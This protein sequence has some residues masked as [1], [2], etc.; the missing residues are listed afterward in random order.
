MSIILVTYAD[1][2]FAE[3]QKVLVEECKKLNIFDKYFSYDFDSLP[4]FLKTSPILSYSKGGGYWLWK[5]YIAIKAWDNAEIG[6]V[7]VVMDS[8]MVINSEEGMTNLI[9]L[10]NMHDTILFKYSAYVNYEWISECRST[11]IKDWFKEEKK[12]EMSEIVGN[13]EWLLSDKIASG[14]I[15]LK[16]SVDSNKIIESWYNISVFRPELFFDELLPMNIENKIYH[17]HDQSVLTALAWKYKN[18]NILIINEEFEKETV[19]EKSAVFAARRRVALIN[20]TP[21]P[22][23]FWIICLKI[24]NVVAFILKKFV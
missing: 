7:L 16:K 22:N 23:L 8:G 18:E 14:L 20:K 13:V 6:D 24:K 12:K 21:N 5:P 15:I 1:N 9:N 3:S 17:R 10:T 19:H 2:K 11:K 4:L